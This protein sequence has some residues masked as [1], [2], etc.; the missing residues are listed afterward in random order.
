MVSA[1]LFKLKTSNNLVS[2]TLLVQGGLNALKALFGGPSGFLLLLHTLTH[3]T[4][5]C[6]F[7]NFTAL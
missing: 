5:Y 7:N 2:K 3:D 4:L 6:K 1:K